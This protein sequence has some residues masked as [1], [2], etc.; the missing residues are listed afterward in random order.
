MATFSANNNKVNSGIFAGTTFRQLVG[1]ISS[2][3][4]DS[5]GN[6][7]P[8]PWFIQGKIVKSNKEKT[9]P[10]VW[11]RVTHVAPK[12]QF[13]GFEVETIAGAMKKSRLNIEHKFFER[14]AKPANKLHSVEGL[15][16]LPYGSAVKVWIT[17]K[18]GER[19]RLLAEMAN[20]GG[21]P[22]VTMFE[23]PKAP[24]PL[25]EALAEVSKEIEA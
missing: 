25:M 5:Q 4:V 20:V 9:A 19:V 14:I 22:V 24:A 15:F 1:E 12:G 16:V 11:W 21:K 6:L 7:V 8:N 17:N 18:D 13:V 10:T 23:A 2:D 3:A